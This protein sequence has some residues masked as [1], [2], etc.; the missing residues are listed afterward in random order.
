ML[1]VDRELS[2]V[3][4]WISLQLTPTSVQKKKSEISF[5][6]LL[7]PFKRVYVAFVSIGTALNISR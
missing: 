7:S 4:Y 6:P 2:V 3:I 1:L 5:S